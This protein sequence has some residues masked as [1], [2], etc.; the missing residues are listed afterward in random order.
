MRILDSSIRSLS[1]RAFFGQIAKLG[2]A[3][4]GAALISSD[5][6]RLITKPIVALADPTCGASCIGPC[7]CVVSNQCGFSVCYGEEHTTCNI[8]QCSCQM[9][10]GQNCAGCYR[11]VYYSGSGL[12]A[13]LAC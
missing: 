3:L 7:V 11:A 4:G 6:V 1:R 2:L 10:C 9:W 12:C 5:I 13:C 8:I